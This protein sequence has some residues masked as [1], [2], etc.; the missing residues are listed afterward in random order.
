MVTAS[1]FK[2]LRQKTLENM[3]CIT[4]RPEQLWPSYSSETLVAY[5]FNLHAYSDIVG[6]RDSVVAISTGYGLDDRRV[7]VRDP[8]GSRIFSSPCRPDRL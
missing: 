1:W 5:S 4:H 8:L 7:G 2:M 6:S 3:K